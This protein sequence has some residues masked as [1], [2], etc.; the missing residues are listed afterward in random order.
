[1]LTKINKEKI[2]KIKDEEKIYQ[3]LFDKIF[4]LGKIIIDT[5]G[6]KN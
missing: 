3:Y 6:I 4:E 2:L 5:K 1:M